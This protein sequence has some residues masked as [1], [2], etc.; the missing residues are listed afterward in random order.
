MVLVA[1]SKFHQLHYKEEDPVNSQS[2]NEL[3]VFK[4]RIREF[5]SRVRHCPPQLAV[6]FDYAQGPRSRTASIDIIK[7]NLPLSPDG[8]QLQYSEKTRANT[9]LVLTAPR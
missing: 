9:Q 8:L 4:S 3:G 5:F 2:H 1:F 6:P 7:N